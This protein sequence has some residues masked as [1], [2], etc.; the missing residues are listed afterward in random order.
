MPVFPGGNP[1][2]YKFIQKNMKFPLRGKDNT[3]A[4]SVYVTFV[5]EKDG[6][7]SNVEALKTAFNCRECNEE[8]IRVV[9][10]MPVWK[11]GKQNGD[12]VRVKFNL[13]IKIN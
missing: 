12:P 2:M 4:G 6:H 3:L 8:A 13:P 7:V 5:V 11:P 1:A 9:R 10:S